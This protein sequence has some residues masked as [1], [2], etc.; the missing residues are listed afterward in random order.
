MVQGRKLY[1]ELHGDH[2]GPALVLCM[3]MGGSCRGWLPLQVPEFSQHRPT[4]IFDYPGVGRSEAGEEQ[5]TTASLADTTAALLDA[6][7]IERADVTRA[8]YFDATR[9]TRAGGNVRALGE[10]QRVI[11]RHAPSKYRGR[12]LIA[13]ADLYAALAR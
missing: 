13:L 3:G 12:H 6:L 1:Y 5:F 2:H 4:L 11:S 10:L 7:E 8:S 9:H